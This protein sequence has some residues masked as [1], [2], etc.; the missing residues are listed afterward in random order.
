MKKHFTLIELLV[1]IAII[2][3]L[4]AMLMPA[5][6]KA[7]EAAKASDC[8]SRLKQ[9]A[10]VSQMY[11][12]D[13]RGRIPGYYARDGKNLG[14]PFTGGV[15]SHFDIFVIGKYMNYG[16][17]MMGC[18]S[19]TYPIAE[20]TG[21]MRLLFT[22]GAFAN[23]YVEAYGVYNLSGQR[24]ELAALGNATNPLYRGVFSPKVSNP[25]EFV[26]F[27]DTYDPVNKRQRYDCKINGTYGMHY[28]HADRCNIA[29]LDG[30][31]D[32]LGPYEV[33]A[34]FRRGKE[35]YYQGRTTLNFIL[36][37]SS[38]RVIFNY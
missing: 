12:G 4:A 32:K 9:V 28:R 36:A 24:M 31:V 16:D 21:N 22:Y 7:R 30:H 33:T 25:S 3:I 2:A 27:C 13:F 37:T 26:M 23:Y 19:I 1:V 17:K 35:D 6:S 20:T 29:F 38:E 34:L 5:L 14:F 18:P 15:A 8:M 11:A 10:L